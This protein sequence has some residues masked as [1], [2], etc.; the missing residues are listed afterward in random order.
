[1]WQAH[2]SC[3][4]DSNDGINITPI[5]YHSHTEPAAAVKGCE[6]AMS[7]PDEVLQ[8]FRTL[9]EQH[10]QAESAAKKN[11]DANTEFVKTWIETTAASLLS[12]LIPYARSGGREML[13]DFG[14]GRP[15]KRKDLG[16]RQLI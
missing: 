13:V 5:A 14:G 4:P 16:P 1:L 10:A 11:Q 6:G 2:G 12:Q 15:Q 9:L 8:R 3:S 7:V